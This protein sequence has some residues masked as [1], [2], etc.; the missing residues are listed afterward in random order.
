M[1][2]LTSYYTDNGFTQEQVNAVNGNALIAQAVIEAARAKTMGNK[3]AAIEKRV[4]KAPVTTKPK[5]QVNNGLKTDIEKLTTQVKK[6][7]RP[8]D[9]VKLRKLQRQL[10]S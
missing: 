10:Q 9:F 4:R 3:N 5:T 6:S 8:E 2:A 1:E 7:G